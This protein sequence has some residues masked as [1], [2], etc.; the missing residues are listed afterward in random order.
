MELDEP[1]I[2]PDMAPARTPTFDTSGSKLNG[3]H[4]ICP[5]PNCAY[6]GPSEKTTRFS[7]LLFIVLF[8][9]WMLPGIIYAIVYGRDIY[10]CPAC[11]TKARSD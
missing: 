6:R 2:V 11:G 7:L 5:N 8:L 10:L 1:M 3:K 9:L 4:I